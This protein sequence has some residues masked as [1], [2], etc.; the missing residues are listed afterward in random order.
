MASAMEGDIKRF[1]A[2]E[3]DYHTS[4]L[5]HPEK[6]FGTLKKVPAS[7]FISPSDLN[8]MDKLELTIEPTDDSGESPARVTDSTAQPV[9]TSEGKVIDMDA[10]TIYFEP[11]G[12]IG[13]EIFASIR[14]LFLAEAE[15]LMATILKAI[16]EQDPEQVEFAAHS[17]KSSS[18]SLGATS[19]PTLCMKLEQSGCAKAI[20]QPEKGA[21]LQAEMEKLK[22][23][24]SVL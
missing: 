23:A 12:G 20:I 9:E 16:A 4:T 15:E 22:K 2:V 3:M 24:L 14:D 18:A 13:S 21:Q 7:T 1:L 5:L 19:L 10:L 6:L 8:T 17:L 11:L